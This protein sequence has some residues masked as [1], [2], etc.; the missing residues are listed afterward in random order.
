MKTC[1][2]ALLLLLSLSA[3]SQPAVYQVFEVDTVAEPRGGIVF[4]NTFMQANLRKPIPAEAAG[5]GGLVI[6]GGTVETDGHVTEVSVIRS[7]RPDCDHEALR[8]FNLFNAWKPAKKEGKAVRQKVT[9]PITFRL[10]TPFI[11]ANGIRIDYFGSDSKPVAG[12]SSQASYKR[13]MPIDTTGLPTGDVVV[14][15]RKDK[16]W[17]EFFRLPLVTKKQANSR[18]VVGTQNDR[19][20]WEGNL[21]VLDNAGSLVQYATYKEGKRIGTELSYHPNGSVAEKKD[22]LDDRS[23]SMTW[24]MN[25]QVKQIKTTDKNGAFAQGSPERVT[26]F[27]DSTGRQQIIDGNGQATYQMSVESK[28]DTTRK[29]L[30]VEQGPYENGFKQGIWTGQYADGSYTYEEK[31]DKGVCQSGTARTNGRTP[32][33]YTTLGQPPEFAGGMQGLGQFLATNL[34]YPISAQRAGVQG[35]VF[36]TFTVCTDGTLCDYDVL[37]GVSPD[38]DKEALRV[39]KRM[40]GRWKPGVQRGEKV[41]VK[42][43]LPINF[44]LN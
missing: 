16:R 2:F 27:W 11:Y 33:Q 20:D 40:S 12:D 41:R 31:Y 19:Q 34:Q 44:T 8:V 28:S 42:Y 32:V 18:S 29:T 6:M 35:R 23:A 15:E 36:V 25:G 7:L 3:V 21:F 13:L 4:L 22:D 38:V 26:A 39:V 30:F 43:N 14:Y 9:I 1:L 5:I 24:Y 37:K 10:N 17:K